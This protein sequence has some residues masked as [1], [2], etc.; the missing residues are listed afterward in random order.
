MKYDFSGYATRAG[1][2][3]SDGRT[4]N[5]DAFKHCDGKKV[6]LVWRHSHDDPENVLG[7]ALLEVRDDGVY[8]YAKFNDTPRGKHAKTLVVHG[9]ITDLSIF[10]NKLVEKAK[11]VVHGMIREVSLVMAGANPGAF[12]D[13]LAVE[14]EDGSIVDLDDEALIYTDE[15]ITIDDVE[16]EHE[17]AGLEHADGEPKGETVGEV[18]NSLSDKQKQ[19]VY[20]L[21]GMIY[22]EEPDESVKMEDGEGGDGMDFNVFDDAG[23]T[24]QQTCRVDP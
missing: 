15:H 13:N 6:P 24:R 2:K 3:C 9:D 19:V 4:I 16:F 22:D 14:H 23:K 5:K 17:D 20:A 7:H 18:F 12:I 11:I 8:A 1:V 21:I 10:A